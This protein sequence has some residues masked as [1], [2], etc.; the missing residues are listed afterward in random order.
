MAEFEIN[1]VDAGASETSF[2]SV[3]KLRKG[4]YVL[5]EGHPCK[6]IDIA[7]SKT[8]KHGHAKANIAGTDKFTGSVMKLTCQLLMILKFLL[9]VGKNIRF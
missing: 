1:E 9:L 3:N 8:E 4:D 2:I 7:K 6:V 5:L